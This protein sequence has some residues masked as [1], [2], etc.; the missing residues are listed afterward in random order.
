L[1]SPIIANNTNPEAI[2]HVDARQKRIIAVRSLGVIASRP[3]LTW[4]AQQVEGG[5]KGIEQCAS[6]VALLGGAAK[7]PN[8]TSKGKHNKRMP[9]H[10]QRCGEGVG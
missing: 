1:I 4:T 3:L 2:I 10:M 5:I 8:Q 6:S 7:N 9:Q